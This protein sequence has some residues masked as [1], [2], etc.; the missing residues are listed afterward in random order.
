MN[1]SHIF[2]EFDKTMND[3]R[4]NVLLMADLTRHNLERAM[5]ALLNHDISIARMVIGDDS[6]V[7][8]LEVKI[9]QIGMDIFVRFHPVA[10]DLRLVISS[11]KTAHNLERISDHAVNIAKRAKKICKSSENLDCSIIEPIY[12]MADNILRDA[13]LSFTTSNVELARSL[14]PSDK[15]LD[16][17]YKDVV[18]TLSGSLENSGDRAENLLHLILVARSLERVGDLAANIGEDSVFL[19]EARDIRHEQRKSASSDGD[20]T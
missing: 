4:D 3:L 20:P 18:A 17:A 13:L 16:A 7:D 6:E 11:M 12:T 15:L 2:K 19:A 8:D 14:K 9:D 1:Q 5:H 10:S